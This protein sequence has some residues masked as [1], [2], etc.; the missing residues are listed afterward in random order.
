VLGQ[1][2]LRYAR[3]SARESGVQVVVISVFVINQCAA[4][5]EE[6]CRCEGIE[7][8]KACGE[9]LVACRGRARHVVVHA[10]FSKTFEFDISFFISSQKRKVLWRR[11][12][13]GDHKRSSVTLTRFSISSRYLSSIVRKGCECAY[14][15]YFS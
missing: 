3:L 4:P 12:R 6:L 2:D 15:Y 10:V 11:H 1:G 7:G 8:E 5:Q 13:A 9:S 14:M